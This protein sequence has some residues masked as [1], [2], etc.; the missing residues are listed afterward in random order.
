M[1]I[2]DTHSVQHIEGAEFV[3]LKRNE[4]TLLLHKSAD[5]PKPAYSLGDTHVLL[6]QDDYESILKSYPHE[7][8]IFYLHMPQKFVNAEAWVSI[9]SSDPWM[10]VFRGSQLGE[11][12][13]S[14]KVH[15]PNYVKYRN[16]LIEDGIVGTINGEV[17]LLKDHTFENHS[18]A[19]CVI[20]GTS[21]CGSDVWK[22][23]HGQ[24]LSDCGL[25]LERG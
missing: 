20:S 15:K 25:G 23:S 6:S 1:S 24:S 8:A 22:N 12:T 3:V 7:E 5:K 2:K 19:A 4:F 10:I 16:K 14:L 18:E 21:Q 17:V 13:P 11:I 9:D